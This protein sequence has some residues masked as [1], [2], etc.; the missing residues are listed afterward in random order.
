LSPRPDSY[1]QEDSVIL[2][3]SS[4][5]RGFQ[6]SMYFRTYRDEESRGERGADPERFDVPVRS[7]PL[8]L[9]RPFPV[10]AI[11]LTASP[12]HMH[13]TALAVP[14]LARSATRAL[15]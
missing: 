4:V 3:Q 2:N 8:P 11:S 9:F 10:H 14:S 7:V 6:R 13:L 12:P 5:D 1:N 15:R